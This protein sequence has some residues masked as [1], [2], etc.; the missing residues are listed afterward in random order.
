MRPFFFLDDANIGKNQIVSKFFGLK[1]IKEAMLSHTMRYYYLP[2]AQ[3]SPNSLTDSKN[4]KAGTLSDS[5]SY[6]VL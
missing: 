6:F 1:S 2:I 5:R 3:K 4:K